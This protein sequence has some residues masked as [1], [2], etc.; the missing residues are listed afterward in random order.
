MMA[1]IYPKV[2]A[3]EMEE[4][5]EKEEEVDGG[6]GVEFCSHGP[7]EAGCQ[8]ATD[9]K[10]SPERRLDLST[11][12]NVDLRVSTFVAFTCRPMSSALV[13]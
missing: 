13:P 10:V 11:S 5:E 2:H 8:N 12:A 9:F 7:T 6:R 3:F 1:T 4:E